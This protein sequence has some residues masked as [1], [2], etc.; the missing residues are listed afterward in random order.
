MTLKECVVEVLAE[1]NHLDKKLIADTYDGCANVY[2]TKAVE[3]LF[4]NKELDSERANV[5]RL[6]I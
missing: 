6:N 3:L 1:Y 2:L 4:K 5:I